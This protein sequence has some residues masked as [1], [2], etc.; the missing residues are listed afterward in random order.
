MHTKEGKLRVASFDPWYIKYSDEMDREMCKLVDLTII[1]HSNVVSNCA[2]ACIRKYFFGI[3]NKVRFSNKLKKIIKGIEYFIGWIRVL[4]LVY[5]EEFDVF[6]IQWLLWY[7]LDIPFL[8]ILRTVSKNPKMKIIITAHNSV[9]HV[10]GKKA[11]GKCGR[12][13]DIVDKVIVHGMGSMEEMQNLYP[14]TRTKLYIQKHGGISNY[15]KKTKEN[16]GLEQDERFDKITK[17][18]GLVFLFLGNVFFNKGTDR[19]MRYWLERSSA[20]G[21]HLLIVAGGVRE[22]SEGYKTLEKEF[23]QLSNAVYW[24]RKVSEAEHDF[25]F[26]NCDIVVLPYRAAS[27][28]GVLFTA[29]YFRKPVLVTNVGCLPEYVIEKENAF[30]VANS[31]PSLKENIDHIISNISKVQLCNMGNNLNQYI[32]ETCSWSRICKDLVEN[33]YNIPSGNSLSS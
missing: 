31:Y 12:I 22:T 17:C 21:N 1:T 27:M 24:D 11:G 30:V 19:L 33:I 29:A 16:S 8:R 14:R 25:L 23:R 5:R 2:H 26:A 18:K 4:L 20:L 9:P 28:S 10:N 15:K 6:H 32:C 13:Y 7:S 3:S